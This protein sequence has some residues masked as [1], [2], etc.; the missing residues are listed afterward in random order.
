MARGI[1]CLLGF[2]H[3]EEFVAE[4][5]GH[6]STPFA[7]LQLGEHR[8]V[9]CVDTSEFTAGNGLRDVETSHYLQEAR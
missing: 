6:D 1:Y 5:V 3:L 4:G 2:V 9:P 7:S 8:L